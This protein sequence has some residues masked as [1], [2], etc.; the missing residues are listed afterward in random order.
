M[1]YRLTFHNE[2]YWRSDMNTVY[3]SR[4]ALVMKHFWENINAYGGPEEEVV[5][6]S[7]WFEDKEGRLIGLICEDNKDGNKS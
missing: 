1:L 6:Y 7:R 3:C 4:L 2:A 5:C